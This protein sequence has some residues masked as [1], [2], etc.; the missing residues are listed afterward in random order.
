MKYGASLTN[1][2]SRWDVIAQTAVKTLHRDDE[3]TEYYCSNTLLCE[4]DILIQLTWQSG[5]LD[6]ACC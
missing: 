3:Q 5:G 6:F 1:T 4:D 2:I